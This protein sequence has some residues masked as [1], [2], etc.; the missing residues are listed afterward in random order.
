MATDETTTD[1]PKTEEEW[2]KRLSPEE[3]RVLRQAG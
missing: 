2:R 3:F 1:L